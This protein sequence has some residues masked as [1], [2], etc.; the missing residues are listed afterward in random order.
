M[1]GE[2]TTGVGYGDQLD[3]WKGGMAN[4]INT[5]FSPAAANADLDAGIG[6]YNAIGGFQLVDLTTMNLYL[7][8]HLPAQTRTWLSAGYSRL[9]SDNIGQLSGT[10]T[11]SGIYNTETA[12]FVNVMKDLSNQ[13]RVEFEYSQIQSTYQDGTLAYD[14]RY[15]VSAFFFF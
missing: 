7:Q 6:G 13:I 9:Y 4:P 2:F 12:A 1:G 8:Y 3:S 10:V 5:N 14:N 11:G 15:Q